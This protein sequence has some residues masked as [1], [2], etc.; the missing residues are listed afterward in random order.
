MQCGNLHKFYQTTYKINTSIFLSSGLNMLHIQ[1][2]YIYIT[3]KNISYIKTYVMTAD[4]NRPSYQF[5]MN[6][7]RPS[8]QSVFQFLLDEF[9]QSL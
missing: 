9:K 7:S 3:T 1:I 6:K 8:Q 5:M 2:K 4:V